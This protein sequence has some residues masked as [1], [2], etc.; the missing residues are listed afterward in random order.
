MS[1]RFAAAHNSIAAL[2]G[3]GN[4]ARLMGPAANDNGAP[5]QDVLL[6]DALKHFAR[7]GLRAA[8]V[9]RDNALAALNLD[10]DISCTHWLGICRTLDRR[11][12]MALAARIALAR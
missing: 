10:D 3:A 2:A 8:Q 1:I 5:A 12:A 9:A 6:R 11:M 7:H 4:H